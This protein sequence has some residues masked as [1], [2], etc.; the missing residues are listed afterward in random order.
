MKTLLG[1]VVALGAW[2]AIPA[3][4][5]DRISAADNASSE[6]VFEMRTYIANPGKLEAVHTRFRDHACKFLKKHGAELV[7][8]WTPATGDEAADTLI[9]I[10]SFPSVEVQKKAWD[11]FRADPAWKKVKADSEKDGVL[12]KE[13]KSK[14]LKATDYSPIR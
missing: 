3:G 9:Y 11:A 8:F 5:N 2:L 4:S 1:I 6:K 13:V 7:G 10:I 12:V 14:N